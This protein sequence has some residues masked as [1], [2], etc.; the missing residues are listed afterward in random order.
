MEGGVASGKSDSCSGRVCP[1]VR[2]LG[3]PLPGK[4]LPYRG[5]RGHLGWLLAQPSLSKHNDHL[6]I[7]L[8][9]VPKHV[10]ILK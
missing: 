9:K 2:W 10:C 1:P 5:A 8:N 7:S 6:S 3:A 4:E